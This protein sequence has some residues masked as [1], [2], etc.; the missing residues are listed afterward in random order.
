[1]RAPRVLTL[2]AWAAFAVLGMTRCDFGIDTTGL[3]GDGQPPPADASDVTTPPADA[4]SDTVGS[5][6]P[7]DVAADVVDE[8]VSDAATADEDAA[9]E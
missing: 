1:M 4:A 2:G 6:A 5:D 8:T 7:P 9:I 3:A